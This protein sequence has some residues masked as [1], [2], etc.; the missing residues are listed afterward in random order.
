LFGSGLSLKEIP[1]S[2]QYRTQQIFDSSWISALIQSGY[3]GFSLLL[4]LVVSTYAKAFGTARDVRGLVVAAVGLII[5]FS[6]MESGTFDT[7]PAF[8]LF[9][10]LSL[11]VYRP[12]RR[13]VP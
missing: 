3:I 10:T 5:M 4:I 9:F 2:A 1:V 11:Y 7:T 6:V 12:R 13:A 8:A